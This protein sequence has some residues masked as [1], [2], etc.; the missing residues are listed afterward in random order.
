MTGFGIA[1]GFVAVGAFAFA[2]PALVAAVVEAPPVG[3]MPRPAIAVGVVSSLAFLVAVIGAVIF[4]AGLA[5]IGPLVAAAELAAAA[6][7]WLARGRPVG[8]DDNGGWTD[9]QPEPPRGP[10]VP[11]EYWRRWEDQFTSPSP[12][13]SRPT[14]VR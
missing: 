10:D 14:L 3:R 7:I 6:A 11:E 4:A 2:T 1:A 9:V 5:V 12:P 8:G 13:R